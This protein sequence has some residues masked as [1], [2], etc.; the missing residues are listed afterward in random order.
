MQIKG[1]K[2]VKRYKVISAIAAQIASGCVTCLKYHREIALRTRISNDEIME[3]VNIALNI[4]KNADKFNRSDLDSVLENGKTS[5][6]IDSSDNCS[7]NQFINEKSS[8]EDP[9]TNSEDCCD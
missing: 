4:R 1:L 5:E 7:S 6:D 9:N 2:L 8:N 3:I